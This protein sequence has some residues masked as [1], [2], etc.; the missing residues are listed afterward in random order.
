MCV[1]ACVSAC[2]VT[3]HSTGALCVSPGRRV[4]TFTKEQAKRNDFRITYYLT[5]GI[6]EEIAQRKID[7]DLKCFIHKQNNITNCIIIANDLELTVMIYLSWIWCSVFI[8][9]IVHINQVRCWLHNCLGFVF[10]IL[11]LLFM[12][13]SSWDVL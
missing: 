10:V 4:T 5:N 1:R 13:C 9:R 12:C 6:T 2:V 11:Y 3:L 7:N 8:Q